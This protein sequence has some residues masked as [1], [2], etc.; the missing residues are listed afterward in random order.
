LSPN[1]DALADRNIELL[2][3][4]LIVARDRHRLGRDRIGNPIP[5]DINGR[6]RESVGGILVPQIHEHPIGL[7]LQCADRTTIQLKFHLRDLG[8]G[9]DLDDHLELADNEIAV[10]GFDDGDPDILCGRG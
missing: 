6:Y 5:L 3:L 2:E 8:P 7:H 10:L 9:H 1:I 4:D